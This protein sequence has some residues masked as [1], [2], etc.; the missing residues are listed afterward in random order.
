MRKAAACALALIIGLMLVFPALATAESRKGKPS[1][2]EEKEHGGEGQDRWVL[3]NSEISIW[4]QGKKPMLKVFG[5]GEDGNKSGYLLKMERLYETDAHGKETNYINLN[6]ASFGWASSTVEEN[7]ELKLVVSGWDAFWNYADGVIP[8]PTIRFIF[9]IN[10]TSAEV[11][12]D[13]VVENWAW[14]SADPANATLSL[15]MLTVSDVATQSADNEASIGGKGYMR[16]EK[17]AQA[18]N[19]NGTQDSLEV[20]AEIGDEGSGSHITL[21]FNGTGGYQTLSYDPT[22]GIYGTN[23]NLMMGIIVLSVAGVVAIVIYAMNKK[24]E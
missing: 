12:F 23:W 6:A 10:T 15:K 17:N 7:D 18:A 3:N 8:I 20:Q 21:T 14:K 13:V 16:W 9:H 4:F 5:T 1:F 22:I 19:N 24:K 2:T 11:K